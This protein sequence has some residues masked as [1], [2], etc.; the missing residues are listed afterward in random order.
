MLKQYTIGT[1]AKQAGVNVE[2]VR[3][4]QRRGLVPQPERPIGGIR[5]YSSVH[6]R[7][8]RFIRQAQTLGFALEEVIDLLA[9]EDGRHCREAERLGSSKLAIV[10]A[11]VAQLR[12]VENA[13]AA[14]LDQCHSNTGKIRCPLIVAME[15]TE[16][17][18]DSA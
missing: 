15:D 8:L 17:D 12:R 6:V 11:R 13:L 10:R 2:T 14:L 3:Y 7:R 4:Y 1:L 5:R 16:T 18:A 9:L